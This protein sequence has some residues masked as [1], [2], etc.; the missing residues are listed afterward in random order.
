MLRT[1]L[2]IPSGLK[3]KLQML[4]TGLQIP[5]GLKRHETIPSGLKQSCPAWVSFF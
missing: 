1:G 3:K 4:R 2:Q 5:S